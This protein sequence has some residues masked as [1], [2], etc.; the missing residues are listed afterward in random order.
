MIFQ[1][2][3]ETTYT[4]SSHDTETAF[5]VNIVCATSVAIYG[6]TFTKMVVS[7]TNFPISELG[8]PAVQWNLV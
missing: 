8:L 5:D 4:N 7:H 2:F 1:P 3:W 6:T